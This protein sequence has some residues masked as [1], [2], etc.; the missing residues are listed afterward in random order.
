MMNDLRGPRQA[1]AARAGLCAACVH[2]RIVAGARGSEFYL[3]ERSFTD[4]RFPRYPAIPVRSC[5]GY[6]PRA[7]PAPE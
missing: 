1:A 5:L 3:C 4:P 2:V 6:E 7:A